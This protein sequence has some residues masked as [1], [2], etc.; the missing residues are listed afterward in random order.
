MKAQRVG[1]DEFAL[2]LVAVMIFIGMLAIYWSSTAETKPYI[3]PREISLS[4]VP[5]ET[6][7]I[8]IKVLAN[9]SSVT[10]ESEGPIS[11]F[12]TF[13]ENN[14]PVFGEKEVRININAPK[15]TGTFV[16][17]IKAKSSAG[18][19]KVSFKLV[20]SKAYALKYRAVTIQDFSVSNYGK[21]KVVDQKERDFVEKSVFSDKKIRLVLQL[22]ESEIEDAYVSVV[23]SESTGPG[24]LVV[25]QN[26]EILQSKKVEVGELKIPLNLTQLQSI[27]FITI[28]ANNPGWNIFG[29]TRYD[30][31]SAKVVVK[32]KGYSQTFDLDLSRDEID[33]FYS[34]EF[35]SLIQTSY[36][37]PTLEIRINDQIAYKNVVPLTGLRL[38]MTKDILGESFVLKEKNKIKFSLATEGYIDFKNNIIKIYSRQ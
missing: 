22:N 32:F 31:Y 26:S 36:P 16:G 21:E 9:A 34:I 17:S 6:V 23:V 4:L 7:K 11:N 14:F 5:N 20:V 13:S 1:F 35:S 25:M 30:I 3:L 19:D 2:I 27:N 10:L 37:V 8:T 29:K 24:E 28:Q 15:S 12:I 18:E 38:N 33:K